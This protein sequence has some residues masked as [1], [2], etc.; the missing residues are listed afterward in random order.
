MVREIYEYTTENSALRRM[1]ADLYESIAGDSLAG[2][3]ADKPGKYK[4]YPKRFLY[5]WVQSML[6]TRGQRK[7]SKEEY[8]KIDVCP[9]FH[10]HEEGVSCTK[11]G[12]KRSRKE[13]EE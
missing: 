11:K 9:Q 5:D 3:M 8:E 13:M 4:D 7:L 12:T 2:N 10:V 1:I 6:R